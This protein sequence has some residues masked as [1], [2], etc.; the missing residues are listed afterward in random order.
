VFS[1]E[2]LCY[3]VDLPKQNRHEAQR[4]LR[5]LNNV[6]GYVSSGQLVALMGE[7]GG[8]ATRRVCA[9]GLFLFLCLCTIP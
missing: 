2:N 6:N 7:L 9:E 5:L 3:E 4:R 8:R 1:W